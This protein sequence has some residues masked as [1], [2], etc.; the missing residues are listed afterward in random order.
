MSSSTTTATIT[1]TTLAFPPMRPVHANSTTTFAAPPLDGS[2]TVVQLLDWHYDHSSSHPFFTYPQPGD[3]KRVITWKET[4]EAVYT[5]A[6]LIRGRVQRDFENVDVDGKV[7]GI[8]S[9]SDSIP[10]TTTMLSVMRANFILFPISPRNSPQ[11]VAHLIDKVGVAHMLVGYDQSMQE[12]MERAIEFLKADYGYGDDRVPTTSMIPLFEDLY[13]ENGE[14]V[15]ERVREEIPLKRQGPQDVQFYLHSSGS[16]AFPKP[17]PYT[18]RGFLELA[19]AAYFGQ[20]DL[21]GKVFSMH[22][23]P[24][25]H[26]MGMFH[27][28]FTIGCGIVWATFPPQLPPIQP[29]PENGI[30]GAIKA[31][32]DYVLCVPSMIETWSRMPS[33]VDW[34]TTRKGVLFGG[35]PL[36]K[37]VGDR[38]SSRGVQLFAIYGSTECGVL[39][40]Y[41]PEHV[42]RDAWDYMRFSENIKTHFIPSEDNTYE[43]VMVANEYFSPRI[44]NT[45]IDGVSAYATADLVVEHPQKKGYWKILGRV[46]S[47]IIHSSG[48]KTNPGPLESIMNQDPHVTASVM[49]G[50]GKFQAGILVEPIPEEQFDPRDQQKLG[51]FR[52]KIWPTVEKMNAFAPQHSRIFKEMILVA[53]PSKPFTYTAKNTPRNSA[54]IREY[55]PEIEAIYNSLDESTQSSIPAPAQWDSESATEFV[56]AVVKHVLSIEDI[57]DEDDIFQRGGDSLQATWIKNSILGALRD[58]AKIDTREATGNF[59]YEHPTIASLA[60]F[61]TSAV[62]NGT[63]DSQRGFEAQVKADVEGMRR[64]LEKYSKGFVSANKDK[65]PTNDR[66]VVLMTGSTGGVGVHILD[67]LLEDPTVKKVYALIRKGSVDIR[68]KQVNAFVERGVDVGLI[69]NEKLVLLEANLSEERFGLQESVFE[70]VKGSVTHIIA[71]AWRVD[72]NISLSSFES[73]IKGLRYMVDLALATNSLLVFV[74]SVGVFQRFMYAKKRPFPEEHLPAEVASGSGYAQGKWVSENIMQNAASTVGLRSIVVR[75]GQ[76][77][78]SPNGS[79]NSKEWLPALVR[80]APHLGCIADD[81]RAMSWIPADMAAC[82]IRDF[83]SVPEAE[84]TGKTSVVHLIHPRPVQWSTLAR[85]IASRLK[86]DVVPFTQWIERLERAG[87]IDQDAERKI[88]ALRILP[89]Y[90][91]I[92]S[93]VEEPGLEAFGLAEIETERAKRLSSTLSDPNAP[94]LGE[95]HVDRWLSYWQLE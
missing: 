6:K 38:L 70:D 18:V 63:L 90:K 57:K 21:T 30:D 69:S 17:I 92:A 84:I 11:A 94:Q 48:E 27:L 22:T 23:I 40:Q 15:V 43:L 4:V 8:L 44:F 82:A 73:D 47:Q 29:T 66:K 71:N 76:A 53:S 87:Q 28:S 58:S 95:E 61:V 55:A 12:L 64:M 50:H 77:C 5:G 35:G 45:T 86:V 42:S 31:D 39:S 62:S 26:A 91:G 83:L 56:R 68:T 36:D 33:Y 88:S 7:V 85:L 79:W 93:V 72:F 2:A 32:V 51:E 19:I 14:E 37:E 24:V 74:S 49:F 16:T 60:A 1:T 10:Y 81:N 52:N 65:S 54:I 41:L 89:F 3:A 25:F 78:G 75:L 34:L 59:V 20:R 46:D 9:Y 80:S 13:L 67:R